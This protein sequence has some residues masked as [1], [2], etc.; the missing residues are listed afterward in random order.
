MT[1]S[2]EGRHHYCILALN[3]CGHHHQAGAKINLTNH[4]HSQVL[5][6]LY[7]PIECHIHPC[8]RTFMLPIKG[9]IA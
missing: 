6:L 7:N 4:S 2:S 9:N 1:P 3:R 8:L 5:A